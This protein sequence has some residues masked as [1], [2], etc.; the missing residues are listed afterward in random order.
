MSVSACCRLLTTGPQL[1]LSDKTKIHKGFGFVVIEII[2]A[3]IPYTQHYNH[4]WGVDWPIRFMEPWAEELLWDPRVGYTN[5]G[6]T[7]KLMIS[8]ILKLISHE[9][10]WALSYLHF[11]VTSGSSRHIWHRRIWKF[12]GINRIRAWKISWLSPTQ[13]NSNSNTNCL[14]GHNIRFTNLDLWSP[15]GNLSCSN[16]LW[17]SGFILGQHWLR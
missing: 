14:F 15:N 6:D 4:I 2:P 12:N 1:R 8:T 5:L 9:R 13:D 11:I 3:S 10:I 7:P 17:P 16:P